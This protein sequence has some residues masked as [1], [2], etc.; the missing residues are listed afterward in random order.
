[1]DKDE[2]QQFIPLKVDDDALKRFRNT[3]DGALLGRDFLEKYRG[4]YPWRVGETYKLAQLAGVSITFV[5]SFTSENAVYNT[6]ILTDRRYLQE[7]DRRLGVANQVYVRVDDAAQADRVITALDRELP[8]R[9]PFKTTTKDQ[10][11]F[12][13]AAVEDLRDVIAF[14]RWVM[15]IT[16]AVVLVA[17]ANTVSMAT[18]DRVQ[19]FGILRSLGFRRGHILALVLGE[20]LVLTLAGGLLGLLAALGFLNLQEQYYGLRGVNLLIYVTPAVAAVALAITLLVGLLGGLLPAIGASRLQIVSS[21]RNV[22]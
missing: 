15:L 4:E 22:D 6:I 7:V 8:Q 17:V 21:L 12:L 20:S 1:M 2:F 16:L 10:R 19:E 9:F 11:A 5:G 14:S 18:R 3:P 13:T